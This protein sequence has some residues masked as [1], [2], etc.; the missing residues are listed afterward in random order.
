MKTTIS[1]KI[2]THFDAEEDLIPLANT[3]REEGERIDGGYDIDSYRW[4]DLQ[5]EYGLI[6]K[7]ILITHT[8]LRQYEETRNLGALVNRVRILGSPRERGYKVDAEAWENLKVD[9]GLAPVRGLGDVVGKVT[10]ALGIDSCAGCNIR[11]KIMNRT[12][13]FSR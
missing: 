11:R 8:L 6:D 7:T 1:D 10:K 5:E 2:L 4:E 13:S 3:V 12:I 9:Y